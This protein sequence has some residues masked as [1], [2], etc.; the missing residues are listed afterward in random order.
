M[1][2][3]IQGLCWHRRSIGLSTLIV[4]FI[5][6]LPFAAS[7]KTWSRS[8]SSSVSEEVKSG[9]SGFHQGPCSPQMLR[10][11]L[12]KRIS[13]PICI[14]ISEAVSIITAVPCVSAQGGSTGGAQ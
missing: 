12:K 13:H 4:V 7:I 6:F 11:R 14:R 3:P 10:L 2:P 9:C 8:K 5:L 1:L